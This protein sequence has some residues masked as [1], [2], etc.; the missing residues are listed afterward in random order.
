MEKSQIPSVGKRSWLPYC[1]Q[2]QQLKFSALIGEEVANSRWPRIL[3]K[4]YTE[5]SNICCV[6]SRFAAQRI[7]VRDGIKPK[8][9]TIL[10]WSS[11]SAMRNLELS[12]V[13]FTPNTRQQVLEFGER[14]YELMFAKFVIPVEGDAGKS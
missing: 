9:E 6:T 2:T 7:I 12:F 4:R 14:N 1:E 8:R 11:E 10:A 3:K 5:F 13:L